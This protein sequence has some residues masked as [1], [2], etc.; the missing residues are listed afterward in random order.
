MKPLGLAE[1]HHTADLICPNCGEINDAAS[2]V[3]E[4]IIGGNP[5]IKPKPGDLSI[6]INCGHFCIFDNKL[7]LRD[8]NEDEKKFW[9]GNEKLIAVSKALAEL[10]K[11]N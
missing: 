4:R 6:C 5:K 2:A 7:K 9:A 10:K 11:R 1:G 3:T 8:M